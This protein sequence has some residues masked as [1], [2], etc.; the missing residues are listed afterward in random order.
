M[1][2][3]YPARMLAEASRLQFKKGVGAELLRQE[4]SVRFCVDKASYLS[5]ALKHSPKVLDKVRVRR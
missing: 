1:C 2:W 3:F 4:R 5:R